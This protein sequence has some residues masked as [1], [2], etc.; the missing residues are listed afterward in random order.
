[1]SAAMT[2][3]CP[4]CHQPIGAMR[5]G[6]RLPQLKA[7]IVDRIK[8]AGDIGVSSDEIIADLYRDRRSVRATTIKA[9]VDQINDLLIN[10]TWRIASDRRRWFLS[11]RSAPRVLERG[12]P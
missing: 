10:T 3:C 8:A 5:F 4:F 6:V 7:A 11:R 12:L 9:H 2:E 1:M